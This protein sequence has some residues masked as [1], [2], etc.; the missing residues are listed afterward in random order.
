MGFFP[1]VGHHNYICCIRTYITFSL[2]TYYFYHHHHYT[3]VINCLVFVLCVY[4]FHSCLL[5]NLP[6]GCWV[7]M[8]INI[9]LNWII[10]IWKVLRSLFDVDRKWIRHTVDQRVPPH[11]ELNY[12]QDWHSQTSTHQI[13]SIMNICGS[14]SEGMGLNST[15]NRTVILRFE[16][17]LCTSR[18]MLK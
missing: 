6:L 2:L 14:Y 9:E 7:S 8:Q 15:Q 4:F 1:Q 18:R 10:S 12:L 16:V 13:Y 5:C 3:D 11:W 17:L